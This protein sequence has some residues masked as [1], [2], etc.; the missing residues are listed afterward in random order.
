VIEELFD[1]IPENERDMM[2][3][4]NAARIWKL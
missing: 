3:E 4:H 1:G 2:V